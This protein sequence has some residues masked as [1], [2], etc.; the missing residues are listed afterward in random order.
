MEAL[1]RLASPRALDGSS[2]LVASTSIG[3]GASP[4]AVAPTVVLAPRN[5]V[6]L[7]AAIAASPYTHTF[8]RVSAR[9]ALASCSPIV[10]RGSDDGDGDASRSQDLEKQS[11][12]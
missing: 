12:T 11:L 7:R 4:A 5:A 2:R 9:R 1:V 3:R 10:S 6:T 8:D